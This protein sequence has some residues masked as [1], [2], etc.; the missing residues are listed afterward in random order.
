[1]TWSERFMK[2]PRHG[3]GFE[4]N[5]DVADIRFKGIDGELDAAEEK[6]LSVVRD[7]DGFLIEHEAISEAAMTPPAVPACRLSSMARWPTPRP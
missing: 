7:Y 5:P 6:L 4:V 2:P 1:M 3:Q